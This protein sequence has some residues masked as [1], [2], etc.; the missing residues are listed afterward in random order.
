[1]IKISKSLLLAVSALFLSQQFPNKQNLDIVSVRDG[2]FSISGKPY[3]FVGVNY[4]PAAFLGMKQYPGDQP[5]LLAELDFLCHQGITNIRVLVASQGDQSYP[6]RASPSSQE[7]A[8]E[9]VENCLQGLDFLLRECGKRRMKLVLYFTNQWEWSGGMGQYLEWNGYGKT[10]LPKTEGWTWENYCSY[11]SR[12]Y[13]CTP[14]KDQLKDLIKKVVTR[15]NIL[16]GVPY[17]D[18]PA[19]FSWELCNEPRPMEISARNAF[20]QWAEETASFIKSLDP[21]HLVT[22]GS[23]GDVAFGFDM[24][25]FEL[26]H[27]SK[28]IDYLTIHI[29]P[30]NWNWFPD[31]AIGQHFPTIIRKS[32]DFLRRHLQTARKLQKPLVLEEFGLPRDGHQFAE[33]TTVYHRN[34]YVSW[35]LAQIGNDT[36]SISGINFWTFGGLVSFPK[37]GEFWKKREPFRGDPPQEEQGLNSLYESDSI[38][39]Q[40]LKSSG[41]STQKH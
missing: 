15:K 29:W 7:K 23:E 26:L 10:P 18:D 24:S 32:E 4:W 2:R 34:R 25:A 14:C 13:F 33:G 6:F 40:L 39:W 37:K 38:T 36:G 41:Y 31:T 19:I 12:F 9:S 22:T 11:M 17:K 28:N 1:M 30:K 20:F 21:N 3:Q 5:R 35:A 8:G 16:T 27:D